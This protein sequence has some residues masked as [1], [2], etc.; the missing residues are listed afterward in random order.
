MALLTV[1]TVTAAGV[2]PAAPTQLTAWTGGDTIAGSDVGA[3]GVVVEVANA[4]GGSLDLRVGDP[5]RTPAGNPV[6]TGYATYVVPTGQSRK[7]WV[8]SASVDP[9]TGAVKI[10]AS[11]T[12]ASF[13][14]R[15]ERY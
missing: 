2:T 5:G 15:V 12:H 9:A 8:G 3:R 7:V 10:G 14:V 11:T 6:A 4:S 13:T 1:Q